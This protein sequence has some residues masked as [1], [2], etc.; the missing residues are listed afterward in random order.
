MI[1]TA[2][3][4]NILSPN[5]II[6]FMLIF[7]RVSGFFQTAPF[8]STIQAPI[9]TK[10][11]FSAIIAFIFFPLV[12]ASKGFILPKDMVEF[13]IL[14]AIEFFVGFLIGFTAN[15]IIEG[16]RMSGSIL[17]IQMGLSMSEALDPA[18]GVNATELSRLYIY[19]TIL[20]FLATGAY[21]MLFIAL[22]NSF[23][24]LPMGVFPI[25]DANIISTL[26]TLFAQVFKIAFGVALPIFS[27]L[28]ISDILLGLMSKM[29]PQMNIYMVA[30]PVKIYIGVFLILAFLSATSTYLQEVI[31]N[32]IQA[33]N[34]LFT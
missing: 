22:F 19:L 18:T 11:W 12:V 21:Q 8:F 10:M 24:A 29:M 2:N 33:I 16:V 28:L 4:V 26:V 20:I 7:T 30:I 15:L 17:S 27:V 32:Y 1:Q 6:I 23:S 13:G 14:L 5:N 31:K 9:I 25:F 3:L 34:L